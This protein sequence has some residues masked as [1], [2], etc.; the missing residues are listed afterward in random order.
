MQRLQ[1]QA[2]GRSGEAAAAHRVHRQSRGQGVAAGGGRWGACCRCQRTM[3]CIL[4]I[5]PL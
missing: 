5:R 3:P 2:P 1:R 4:P